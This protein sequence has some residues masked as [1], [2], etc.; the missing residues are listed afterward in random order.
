[1]QLNVGRQGKNDYNLGRKMK[2]NLTGKNLSGLA[3]QVSAVI[4]AS[5][6]NL[7]ILT[8]TMT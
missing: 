2:L 1:M 4:K 3:V 8:K 5:V 6:L 7:L